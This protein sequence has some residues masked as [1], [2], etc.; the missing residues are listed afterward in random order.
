M[1]TEIICQPKAEEKIDNITF[2]NTVK[3]TVKQ[4]IQGDYDDKVQQNEK[5]KTLKVIL[6]KNMKMRTLAI[7]LILLQKV[8][9]LK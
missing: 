2:I 5:M 3:L 7:V 4:C 8:L 6:V 1:P 9:Y